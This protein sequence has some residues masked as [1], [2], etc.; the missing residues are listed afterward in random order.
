MNSPR[1]SRWVA[2]WACTALGI[3][4]AS[5]AQ[6]VQTA[7]PATDGAASGGLEEIVVTANKREER[8]EKVGLSITAITSATLQEQHIVSLEDVAASVPGLQFSA[9]TTNTPILTLR[10]VGYNGNSLGAYPA[11]S[12]YVDEAPLPFPIMASHS[13]YDLTRI[14]VLKGP[15]GTLFGENSTGGAINYI[16]SKPT[17]HFE[18]GGDV[19]YGRFNEAE[20]NFYVSGP[21]TSGLGMRFAVTAH[22]MDSW[23][24]SYTRKDTNGEQSYYAARFITTYEPNEKVHLTLNLNGWID[25]SQPVAPQFVAM[26]AASPGTVQPQA[27]NYP[28]GPE[29]PRAADWSTGASRPM[30]D[31][32]FYQASLRGDLNLN[33]NLTLTSL[34]SYDDFTQRQRSDVDGTALAI[35]DLLRDNGN[36]HSFNQELRLAGT[37]ESTLRWIVGGNY[38]HSEVF[39]DQIT[40]YL[41]DSEVNA[42]N[43]FINQSGNTVSQKIRNYAFFGNGEYDI[44]PQLTLRGGVRYTNTTDDASICG[45]SPGD[46]NVA[47]LF[48][49]LGGLLGK[50]PFT[51]VGQTDCYTLNQNLVPGFP[52]KSELRQ[53][54]ISWRGGLDYH[55]DAD[56]LAYFNVSKGFKAGSYPSLSAATYVQL[57][58]VSQESVLA[59]EVGIKSAL[60]DHRLQVNAA[61]FYYNY[62]D[63]QVEGKEFDP[64]FNTLNILVNVPKSRVFG[65]EAEVNVQ[66]VRG[67][68][69][70]GS[71][72]YLQSKI[73]EYSGINVLVQTQNFAGYR[74]PFTP[75]WSYSLNAEYK[76]HVGLPGSP[77]VGMTVHGQSQ[78]DTVIGGNTIVLPVAQGNRVYPGLVYPYVTNPYAVTDARVGYESDDAR[79]RVWL[80]GKNVFNRY[81]WNNVV[82]SNDFTA[83]FVGMP[84]TFGITASMK[85]K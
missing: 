24:Q 6:Q 49:I 25:K 39:E 43:L 61:T 74:L 42:A 1:K 12:L 51:P 67:L 52:F 33:D 2:G 22:N 69:L 83:R 55:I 66:P 77:F 40:N 82:T 23:Q 14:E 38:E 26:R 71:V 80:W 29:D 17:D 11:V 10:G 64:I 58:P 79:W 41:D 65:A 85:F 7:Q 70:D 16:A 28:F 81:Y 50:V 60:W 3:C 36:I 53:H 78:S 15:Q 68:S 63:K 72:T 47:T 13:A 32:R 9:T 73:Q 35:E 76:A 19:T 45:Y 44:M 20:E 56:T 54:N 37:H 75:A 31:R 27:Q 30:S 4:S 57:Q 18:A 21:I 62:R 46:G 48:N 34:T 8:L 59:Y 84:A 5:T